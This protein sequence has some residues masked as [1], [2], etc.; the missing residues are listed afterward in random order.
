MQRNE[1]EFTSIKQIAK[2]TLLQ[3]YRE[4]AFH[5]VYTFREGLINSRVPEAFC[6]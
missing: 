2:I 1:S 3:I 5:L 4:E 6:F